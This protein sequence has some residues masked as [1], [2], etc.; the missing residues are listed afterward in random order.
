[1]AIDEHVDQGSWHLVGDGMVLESMDVQFDLIW[2]GSVTGDTVVATWTHHFDPGPGGSSMA[3]QYEDDADGAVAIDPAPG[4]LLVL[5][6][7]A[8]NGTHPYFPNGD[9]AATGGRIPSLTFP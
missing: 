1:M 6:F 4:D 5:R 2:R 9:G 7:T 8:L 3:V